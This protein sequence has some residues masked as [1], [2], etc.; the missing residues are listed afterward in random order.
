MQ[1]E[2]DLQM[3]SM[4]PT[5]TDEFL[6]QAKILDQNIDKI[7]LTVEEIKR[8]HEKILVSPSTDNSNICSSFFRSNF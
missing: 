1:N 2:T 8:L 6:R 7:T 4:E 5:Q 3:F